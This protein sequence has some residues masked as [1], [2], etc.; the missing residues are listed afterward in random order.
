MIL[1]VQG[2]RK[3]LIPDIDRKHDEMF[4]SLESL[5]EI[6]IRDLQ[7]SGAAIPPHHLKTLASTLVACQAG[8]R[9][10]HK[11]EQGISKK[12]IELRES[13][14]L[15]ESFVQSLVEL[16]SRSN[17]SRLSSQGSSPLSLTI[18]DAEFEVVENTNVNDDKEEE[19]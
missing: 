9:T 1:R 5:L 17:G 15:Y 7:D 4:S 11:K 14:K 18:M 13:P 16:A 3:S 12:V 10:V 19:D 2:V 6:T 8:R